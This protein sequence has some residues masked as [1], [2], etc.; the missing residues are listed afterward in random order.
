[1]TLLAS[2]DLYFNNCQHRLVYTVTY[3]KKK[4]RKLAVGV[5]VEGSVRGE[6]QEVAV[7]EI[8]LYIVCMHEINSQRIIKYSIKIIETRTKGEYHID[9]LTIN[10]CS[11]LSNT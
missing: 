5:W 7:I 6:G 4:D 9:A 11:I 1:M 8:H 10:M 3:I 2:R